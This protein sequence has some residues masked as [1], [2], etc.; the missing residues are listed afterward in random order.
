MRDLAYYG[1][2]TTHSILAIAFALGSGM[3][4]GLF[5]NDGFVWGIPLAILFFGVG[6]FS[7]RNKWKAESSVMV[8]TQQ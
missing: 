5:F 4:L 3:E 1:S 2:P 7:L 8:E 6:I